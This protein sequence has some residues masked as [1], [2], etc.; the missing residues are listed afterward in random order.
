MRTSAEYRPGSMSIAATRLAD[1]GVV[2]TPR[3]LTD[4]G[5]DRSDALRSFLLAAAQPPRNVDE[6]MADIAAQLAANARGIELLA[7]VAASI[8]WQTLIEASQ[9]L[10]AAAEARVRQFLK[11]WQPGEG[12]FTDYLDDG[13]P[14]QLKAKLAQDGT[15][16]LDFSG[17]GPCSPHNFNANPSIVHAAVMYVLRCLIA[18][19]LPL[20]EGV[21]RCVRL[22]LPEGLLNPKP[23]PLAGLSPAVAAGNVETSQRIVDVLLGAFGAAAASQGTMNNLLFG[24][25]RFGFYETI[26]GGAGAVAGCRG[27]SG[28]HTHMTNTRLTDP[29]ILEARYPVRLQQFRLRVDSGGQ[30]R[31]PGGDG[32]VRSIEFLQTVQLSLLTSR[33]GPFP[34]FGLAGGKPGQIGH[35]VLIGRDGL[36]RQLP[37]CVQLTV[38]AGECLEL[39]TPGGGGFGN[40][41]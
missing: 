20:N 14:I 27:A 36:R 17:T 8:G 9:H 37:A 38:Q 30:G 28:V 16:C 34:P 31:W 24:N 7:E 35:N 15:L 32:V 3:K 18:D 1:E 5:N 21:M 19:E 25:E 4:A 26:C 23:N 40:T 29:E 6:N 33:R 2:I 22:V 10:L 41:V 12:Q 39:Q 11:R 13:T